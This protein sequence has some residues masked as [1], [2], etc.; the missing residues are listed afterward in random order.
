MWASRN[1]SGCRRSNWLSATFR[2]EIMAT[3]SAV[4]ESL[5]GEEQQ[6]QLRRAVIAS[7]VGSTIEW[8]DFFLYSTV[9]GVVVA[10]LYF[11]N[12]DP[13]VGTLQAFAIYAAGF[14]VVPIGAGI[15]GQ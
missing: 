1:N 5:S 6:R 7:T 9:T 12:W 15:F 3:P 11:P 10:K 4:F 8:Y 13:L 2:E 14:V